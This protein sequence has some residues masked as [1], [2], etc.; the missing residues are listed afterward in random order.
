MKKIL[1]PTDFSVPAENAVRYAVQLAK[2]LEAD[3][4]LCNAIKVP[5]EAPMAAQVVWP[6]MDY[7]TLKQEAASELDALVK[8]LCDPDNLEDTQKKCP[9]ITYE[10][11]TGTVYDV[12]HSLVKEREVDLVVMG[13]AGASGVIQFLLGSNSKDMIEKADFPVL[14]VPYSAS[15]KNI[16]KIVFATNFDSRELGPLKQLV[17]LASSLNAEIT[18]THITDKEIDKS[19]RQQ[20]KMDVF[21]SDVIEKI[22][23]PKKIKYEK[24]WNIAVDNGLNWIISQEDI[25]MVAIVHHHHPVLRR[26]FKGS[27]TQKL[28]RQIEVPLLVFPPDE[29][30]L[31]S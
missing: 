18:I 14:F 13:M 3:V 22:N 29:S 21:M 2:M 23:H 12:V 16:S 31:K 15:F 11:N 27:H 25:D 1:I 19:S 20:H 28:S 24:I 6:L 17:N 9:R 5:A 30:I 8:K 10:S 26:I 7:A 4:L